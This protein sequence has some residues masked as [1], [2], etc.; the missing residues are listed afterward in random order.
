MPRPLQGIWHWRPLLALLPSS[1]R[2][3]SFI[4]GPLISSNSLLELLF[5]SDNACAQRNS[6]GV[7]H[8][9]RSRC[10][11]FWRSLH[12]LRQAQRS[13]SPLPSLVY[14]PP[15]SPSALFQERLSLQNNPRAAPRRGAVFARF[16]I[17]FVFGIPVL[18]HKCCF[19]DHHYSCYIFSHLL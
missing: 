18:A 12:A 10:C 2:L 6:L 17:Q 8:L 7:P 14:V 15:P 16:P 9:L 4:A 3:L 1:P 13:V 11:F 19:L 5:P